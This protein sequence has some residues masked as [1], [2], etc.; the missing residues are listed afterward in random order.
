MV[1]VT[2]PPTYSGSYGL[3]NF[4][5]LRVGYVIP[6]DAN[7]DRLLT[8]LNQDTMILDDIG[9]APAGVKYRV[10]GGGTFTLT[11]LLYDPAQPAPGYRFF[12]ANETP[13]QPDSATTAALTIGNRFSVTRSGKVVAILYYRAATV[14]GAATVGVFSPT[15][16][17]LGSQAG[18]VT[19]GSGWVTETLAS[20]LTLAPGNLY[21]LAVFMP[22]GHYG[23]TI[24]GA[25]AARDAGPLHITGSCGA[26]PVAVTNP[27]TSGIA[28]PTNTGPSNAAM[29]IDLLYDAS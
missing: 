19:S 24:G 28:Y 12:P 15:G 4:Y 27:S 21:T 16:T 13:S 9:P 29:G 25:C 3:T 1:H 5:R 18:S 8:W 22:N 14:T 23:S 7:G 17:L 11:E 10:D 2:T 6:Y 20:P 26:T